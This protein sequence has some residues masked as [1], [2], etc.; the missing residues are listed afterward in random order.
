MIT[1]S[2]FYHFTFDFSFTFSSLRK[3]IYSV[4]G[5][6]SEGWLGLRGFYSS[7]LSS[8]V[9]RGVSVVFVFHV[10][11][12]LGFLLLPFTFCPFPLSPFFLFLLISLLLPRK[13]LVILYQQLGIGER[14]RERE[15]ELFVHNYSA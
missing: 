4:V 10:F 2:G 7:F 5:S 8:I 12:Q 1:A 9:W 13:I 3:K 14:E 15:R 11:L 6:G